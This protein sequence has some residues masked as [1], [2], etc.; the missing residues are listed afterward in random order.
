MAFLIKQRIVGFF[1]VC[2]MDTCSEPN[3]WLGLAHGREPCPFL[4]SPRRGSMT[5]GPNDCTVCLHVGHQGQAEWHMT[6]AGL[7]G[8]LTSQGVG[9]KPS[10]R[11]FRFLVDKTRVS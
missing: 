4:V 11:K 10:E 9:T 7:D 5:A 6:R 1:F 8:A 3:I 2:P